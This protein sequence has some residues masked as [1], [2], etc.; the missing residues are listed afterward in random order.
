[1]KVAVVGTGYVGLVAGACLAEI[2]HEVTCV[3][4]DA[5]KIALLNDG[6]LPIY[7]PGLEDLV[8][9]NVEAGRLSFQTDLAAAV[10][11]AEIVFIA[12][13]TPP[14]AD[15]SA[16]LRAVEAVAEGIADALDGYKV[17]GVKSTVPIGTC[18]RVRAIIASRSKQHFD[19]VS[20][21]EF[22]REGVAVPDFLRPDRVILGCAAD[23]ARER[24]E[25]LY[26][27]LTDAG[28][29]LITMDLRSAEL[30][31]Y[32]SNAMLATRISFMNEV[33][34]LCEEVGADVESVREGMGSDKRIGPYFLRAGLGYG[35]SCFPKDV[36][37][38][39]RTAQTYDTPL[40]LLE[41]VEQTNASQKERMAAVLL[42]EMGADLSGRIVAVWGLAF[43]PDTDDMREA[44]S[45]PLIRALAQAGAA[46][47]VHDPAAMHTA[48]EA[49]GDLPRYFEDPY[50]CVEGAAALVLVTEWS[51]YAAPDW[52]RI[53]ATVV[54]GRVYDGRNLWSPAEVRAAGLTYR[55][56]GR[57]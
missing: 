7:E 1:M 40:R 51:M 17:V 24:M 34:N 26:A 42:N 11:A 20:N 16:D 49:L 57:R 10:R 45:I 32:A 15:G 3:D 31:K 41:A 23:E 22:L 44:P 53:A 43:K 19:V 9:K 18:E 33:A 25:R 56:I 55:G 14:G 30:T 21:P 2:G 38:L 36:K 8:P 6:G 46:V 5:T 54:E 13:G 28:A 50:A 35:G 27:P 37:A 29:R 47:H 4:N 12:V 52:A 48:R 39:L